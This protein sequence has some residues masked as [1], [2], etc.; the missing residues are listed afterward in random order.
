MVYSLYCYVFLSDRNGYLE[1]QP[2]QE[3]EGIIFIWQQLNRF[4][5][6]VHRSLKVA[7]VA[8][9]PYDVV[10]TEEARALA[11]DNELSFLHVSRPESICL[12]AQIFIQTKSTKRQKRILTS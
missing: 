6:Y 11:S 12:M 9:V 10:N 1:I 8:S 5:L 2:S 7:Q 4:E 3:S